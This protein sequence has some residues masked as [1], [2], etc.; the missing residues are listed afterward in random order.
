MPVRCPDN[1]CRKSVEECKEIT[2]CPVGFIRCAD[3]TCKRK[4]SDCKEAECPLNFPN[5]C[6]NGICV[7]D[8]TECEED[9]ACPFYAKHKC[10]GGN[11]V[12]DK[13]LCDDGVKIILDSNEFQLC[14][15][16]SVI[17]NGLTC[18]ESNGCPTN[19]PYL[20]G[21]GECRGTTCKISTCPKETPIK[22]LNGLCV[23]TESNCPSNYNFNSVK[24]CTDLNLIT[25][26]NGLCARF[27]EECK[28]TSACAK[29]MTKCPD[30][31]C[32]FNE[33]ECPKKAKCPEGKFRCLNGACV[34]NRDTD[35]LNLSGCPL[36]KKIKC[37]SNGLC[38]ETQEDC[39]AY[40]K[41]FAL[42]NGCD[43]DKPFKCGNSAKCVVDKESCE[44]SLCEGKKIFCP[45][46]GV[47]KDSMQECKRSTCDGVTCPTNGLC[48]KKIEEC[49]T[50][51]GCDP[52][53]P[54]R[55]LDGQ[56]RKFPFSFGS[57]SLKTAVNSRFLRIVQQLI[58]F[59]VRR[60]ETALRIILIVSKKSVQRS[61]RLTASAV[62][63]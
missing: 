4:S 48:V 58:L 18:P 56:C 11:C 24:V 44:E 26:A 42:A 61:C 20:C 55:C 51:K 46:S 13:S 31:T 8:K 30:G 38:V 16:G 28:P 37:V 32:R 2:G 22:C 45:N 6:N 33:N 54:Y 15:D 57:K 53:T 63:A 43:I 34:N 35:C 1:Q 62:Y 17:L 9:N 23:I 14:K 60:M 41:K 21:N 10:E 12:S 5:M 59:C 19:K 29:D 40:D 50:Q 39:A 36:N 25:C 49:K 3:Q 47:C 52:K 7:K 27:P